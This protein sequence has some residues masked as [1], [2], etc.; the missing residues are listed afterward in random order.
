MKLGRILSG[1]LAAV[2]AAA[3]LPVNAALAEGQYGTWTEAGDAAQENVD[4]IVDAN[5]NYTVM[6]AL[7]LA[8]IANIV[9]GSGGTADDLEG[10]SV[11]LANEIDLSAAGV[12]G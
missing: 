7:G 1:A 6:T 5:G 3:M 9:N 12:I 8:K 10:K 11:T 4:Y 2:F